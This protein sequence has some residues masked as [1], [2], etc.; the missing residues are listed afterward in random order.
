MGNTDLGAFAIDDQ[1]DNRWVLTGEIDISVHEKFREVWA[2]DRRASAP[3]EVDMSA[4]TFIDSSGLRVL[5][6][7][8]AATPEGTLATLTGVPAQPRWVI[9]VTGLTDLFHFAESTSATP[10]ES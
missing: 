6:A 4:V 7:A 9:E 1:F 2:V 3:V 5:Y 10:A 8:R